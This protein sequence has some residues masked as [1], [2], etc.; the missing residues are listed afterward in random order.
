MTTTPPV[1]R[2]IPDIVIDR[3]QESPPLE[4]HPA[5]LVDNDA[6]KPTTPNRKTVLK[7]ISK[8]YEKLV[9]LKFLHAQSA[10]DCRFRSKLI[11]FPS[12]VISSLVGTGSAMNLIINHTTFKPEDY[13]IATITIIGSILSL[14]ESFTDYATKELNHNFY[15]TRLIEATNDIETKLSIDTDHGSSQYL[16]KLTQLLSNLSTGPPFTNNAQQK[17][18]S[19]IDDMTEKD[20][21]RPLAVHKLKMVVDRRSLASNK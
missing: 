16:E 3:Q 8:V 17:L 11:S 20:W 14:T 10:T 4:I 15:K 19:I 6:N 7:Q 1:V 9:S 12:R 13:V 2:K 18:N 5:L 21:E